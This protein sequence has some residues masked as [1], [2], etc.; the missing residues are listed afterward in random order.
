MLKTADFEEAKNTLAE[1]VLT[2][3]NG[4]AREPTEV[5]FAAVFNRY[6]TEHSDARPNP[7]AAR[8]AGTLLLEFFDD[9]AVHV[10]S[11]KKTKQI[12]FIRHL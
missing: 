6:W 11:F 1:V 3:G 10:S 2:E 8:R 5:T 9:D 7:S 12:E 4:T